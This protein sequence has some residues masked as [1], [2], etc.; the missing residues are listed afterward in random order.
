MAKIFERNPDSGEIR[1]RDFGD[2][3]NE[4]IIKK[5]R[6]TFEKAS[7]RSEILDEIWAANKKVV[8]GKWYVSLTDVCEILGED[9][10][11]RS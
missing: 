4:K 8:D 7:I 5:G 10:N 3:G 1:S 2:Y 6:T 11:E 9:A